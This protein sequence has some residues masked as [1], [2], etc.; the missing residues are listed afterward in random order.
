VIL[1]LERIYNFLDDIAGICVDVGYSYPA[2]KYGY[3]S[4]MVHQLCERLTGSRYL[5]NA[6]VPCGNNIEFTQEKA[7]DILNTLN[8]I[9]DRLN[10][11]IDMT[12]NAVTFLDRVEHTGLVYNE[13]A[14]K[15]CMTGIVGRA[16]GISYD[17]RRS[18]PYEIYKSVKSKVNTETIGGVFERYKL[19][20]QEIKDAFAI[21]EKALPIITTNG[22]L[23]AIESDISLQEGMEAI[24]AVETVKGELVVYGRVGKNN[25]FDRVYFKTPSFTDWDGLTYAVLGEIVPDF[26]LCNKSFNMSYSENDR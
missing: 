12:L 1:E 2:K 11:I 7:Q 21:I 13:K 3:F 18:F 8:R 5:R 24:A 26:P 10:G 6:V 17:V 22:S 16:S 15:L 9:K 19:K 14:K 25:K 4:E 23:P 20:V